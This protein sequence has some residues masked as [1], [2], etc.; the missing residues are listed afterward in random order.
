MISSSCFQ[1]RQIQV[2]TDDG[3]VKA[4]LRQLGQPICLFGEGPADR[5]ER[6]RNLLA[7]L[8]EDALKKQKKEEEAQQQE[9]DE[10]KCKL[11]IS[12]AHFL[13]LVVISSILY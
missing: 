5:R 13:I 9:K 6:L 10:V 3:E 7:T 4:H 12:L 2:S 11:L 8:G 1:A